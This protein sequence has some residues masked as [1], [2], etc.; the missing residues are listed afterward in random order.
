VVNFSP[1]PLHARERTPVPFVGPRVYLDIFGEYKTFFFYREILLF[2]K[3]AQ[4]DSGARSVP[5][6][7]GVQ[8][9]KRGVLIV[10]GPIT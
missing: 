7:V 3:N 9:L 2:S 4:T 10:L 5:Y 1:R 8:N 6:S